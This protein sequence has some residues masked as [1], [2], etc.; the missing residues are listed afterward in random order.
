M[1]SEQNH[2]YRNHSYLPAAC[3]SAPGIRRRRNGNNVLRETTAS[4]FPP[5]PSEWHRRQ[6]DRN[7]R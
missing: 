6:H 3:R 7:D 1:S 2:R 4:G 5:F